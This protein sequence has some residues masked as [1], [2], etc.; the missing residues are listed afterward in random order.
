MTINMKSPERI[1]RSPLNLNR[2]AVEAKQMA[3]QTTMAQ[4]VTTTERPANTV[5]ALKAGEMMEEKSGRAPRH[6]S[7]P[8]L[9]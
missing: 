9:L 5:A 1:W 2:P 6:T 4:T 8:S 3:S 7:S